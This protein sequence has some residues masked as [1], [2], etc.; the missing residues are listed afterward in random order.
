[1]IEDNFHLVA[2]GVAQVHGEHA[3]SAGAARLLCLRHRRRKGLAVLALADEALQ[4]RAVQGA[5]PPHEHVRKFWEVRLQEQVVVKV[6]Y[7][8][9]HQVEHPGDRCLLALAA[10]GLHLALRAF[11]QEHLSAVE[12]G[13][14]EEGEHELR[15]DGVIRRLVRAEGDASGA[16]TGRPADHNDEDVPEAEAQAPKDH[17][18][19]HR[20]HEALLAEIGERRPSALCAHHDEKQPWRGAI[21]EAEVLEAAS[22]GNNEAAGGLAQKDRQAVGVA[23]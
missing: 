9:A 7:G 2:H 1:M 3:G 6:D 15:E 10:P 22:E 5:A 4:G 23:G 17:G 20:G 11:S 21:A 18:Q 16:D 12:E 14:V 13:Q 19:D 8:V